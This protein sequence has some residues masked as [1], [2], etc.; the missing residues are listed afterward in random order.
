M[1]EAISQGFGILS[2]S[3]FVALVLSI[4]LSIMLAVAFTKPLKKMKNSAMLLAE[5]DY[6]AKT[7]V[8][9][10]DEIGELAATIDGLSERLSIASHESERLD[11][12]RRDFVANI[13]HELRTPVLSFEA[14]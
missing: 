3:I 2:I 10:K 8:Q 5:G 14:H 11:Q 7:G 6:N 4:L 12:L 13:S 9:Q 1:N